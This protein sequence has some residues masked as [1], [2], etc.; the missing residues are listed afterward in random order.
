MLALDDAKALD[1]VAEE[2]GH[3]D[4]PVLDLGVTK[5]ADGLVVVE[6]PE[7]HARAAERVPEARVEALVSSCRRCVVV[8]VV[9]S[10]SS[11]ASEFACDVVDGH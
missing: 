3:R 7:R 2:R 1:A 11:S 4:A 6:R 5:V 9:S 10:S 8:V